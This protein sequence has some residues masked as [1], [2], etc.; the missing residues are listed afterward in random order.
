MI[1]KYFI[2]QDPIFGEISVTHQVPEQITPNFVTKRTTL[3]KH[4]RNKKK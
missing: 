3:V 2:T 4:N 1:I